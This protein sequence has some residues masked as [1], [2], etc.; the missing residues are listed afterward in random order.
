[1]GV[2]DFSADT[3]P[4]GL[5]RK[6][7]T[8]SVTLDPALL[9]SAADDPAVESLVRSLVGAASA[10]SVVTIAAGVGSQRHLDLARRLGVDAVQGDIVG[11]LAPLEVYSDL[12][13]SGAAQLPGGRATV[14]SPPARPTAPVAPSEQVEP[15]HSSPFA[16]SPFTPTPADSTTGSRAAAVPLSSSAAPTQ[17]LERPVVE[18]VDERVTE[19]ITTPV[20]E[21]LTE[22]VAEPTAEPSPAPFAPQVVAPAV[23]VPRLLLGGDIGESLARELGLT[24]GPLDPE[25]RLPVDANDA[26][27]SLTHEAP[28]TPTGD[29]RPGSST[30]G[31]GPFSGYV[32]PPSPFLVL[33]PKPAD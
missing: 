28:E 30:P 19:P 29:A 12:L 22:P 33:R 21:S 9:A 25:P 14:A 31:A 32:L 16:P 23:E 17:S 7:E 18:P 6:L 26:P 11:P 2:V 5:L 24:L 3:V 13:L 8:V 15:L 10:L 20:T 1:V 4:V 27:P